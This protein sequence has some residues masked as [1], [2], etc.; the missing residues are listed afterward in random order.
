MISLVLATLALGAFATDEECMAYEIPRPKILPCEDDGSNPC[1]NSKGNCMKNRKKRQCLKDDNCDW[2]EKKMKC[3]GSSEPCGPCADTVPG[4]VIDNNLPWGGTQSPD[5]WY[6]CVSRWCSKYTWMGGAAQCHYDPK[7]GCGCEA[8]DEDEC[9]SND[10]CCWS[11]EETGCQEKVECQRLTFEQCLEN[12]DKC[13][14]CGTCGQCG[15][16]CKMGPGQVLPGFQS[17]VLGDDCKCHVVQ[18]F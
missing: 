18:T 1:E 12:S 4:S 3:T 16:K 9:K 5:Y 6:N 8:M 13:A 15:Y 11:G 14:P 17:L 10:E 7:Y 2:D